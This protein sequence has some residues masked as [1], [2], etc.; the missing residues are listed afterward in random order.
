[1]CCCIVGSLFGSFGWF[2]GLVR[3]VGWLVIWCVWLV[4][5]SV[6]LV[7]CLVWRGWLF[8]LAWLVYW[9]GVVG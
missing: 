1:M 4:D 9:F 2:G 3:L 7:G 6:W 5:G 8:G